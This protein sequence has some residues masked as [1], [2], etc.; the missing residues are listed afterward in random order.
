[1]QNN[2]RGT[3]PPHMNRDVSGRCTEAA[4]LP[5]RG[6]EKRPFDKTNLPHMNRREINALRSSDDAAS[7]IAHNDVRLA[8]W[9]A[10]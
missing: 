7:Q 9:A 1:M 4:A 5:P 2:F 6:E 3:N 10:A 8:R